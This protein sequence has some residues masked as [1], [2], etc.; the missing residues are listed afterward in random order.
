MSLFYSPADAKRDLDASLLGIRQ[1]ME[2]IQTLEREARM[3]DVITER[4]RRQDEAIASLTRSL[5]GLLEV[6]Q[7]DRGQR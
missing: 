1:K 7:A 3:L 6:V 4:L 2:M 5:A